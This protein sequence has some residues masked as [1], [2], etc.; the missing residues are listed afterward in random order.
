MYPVMNADEL[1]ESLDNMNVDIEQLIQSNDLQ[2]YGLVLVGRSA[3]IINFNMYTPSTGSSYIDL[4]YE[5]KH[6]KQACVN[7][8]NEDNKC[9]KYCVQAIVLNIINIPHPGNV[10]RLK[11]FFF[12]NCF[13]IGT[14]CAQTK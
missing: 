2:M 13:L 9:G 7:I 6:K 4:P 5:I 3:I 12:H 14:C 11:M 10:S 8:Q 1:T